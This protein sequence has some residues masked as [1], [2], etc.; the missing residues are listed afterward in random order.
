MTVKVNVRVVI[1]IASKALTVTKY[2]PAG[3]A[4]VMRTTPVV[5]LATN[6]PLKL[7]FVETLILVAPVGAASGVTIVLRRR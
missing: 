5:G 3:C 6:V 2:E 7:L 1:P 4:L